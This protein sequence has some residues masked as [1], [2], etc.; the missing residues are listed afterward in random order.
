MLP[1]YGLNLYVADLSIT[2]DN[3]DIQEF[4]EAISFSDEDWARLV[5]LY[6]KLNRNLVLK[7]IGHKASNVIFIE[8]HTEYTETYILKAFDQL[9]QLIKDSIIKESI[10]PKDIRGMTIDKPNNLYVYHV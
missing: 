4:S 6:L 5:W 1:T 7:N 3:L 9:Y 10:D 8:N 2:I